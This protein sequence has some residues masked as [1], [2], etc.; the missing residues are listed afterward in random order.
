MHFGANE[1]WF[2]LQ[3]EPVMHVWLLDSFLSHSTTMIKS[4]W[5]SQKVG[6]KSI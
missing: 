2:T 5:A 6:V 3:F 4:H 1:A